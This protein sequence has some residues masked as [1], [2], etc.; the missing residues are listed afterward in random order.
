[1]RRMRPA[2]PGNLAFCLSGGVIPGSATLSRVA[3]MGA[4]G[5]VLTALFASLETV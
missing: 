4:R 2:D 1:M 5:A 3:A